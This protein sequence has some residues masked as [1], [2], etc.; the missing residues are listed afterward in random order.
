MTDVTLWLEN[1]Y[2]KDM[3]NRK[4]TMTDIRVII[5]EFVRGT[6]LREME[7]KLKISRTSLRA[8]RDR[9]EASGK[10]M[11][12]LLS[13]ED[14][15][16]NAILVKG[17]GHRSR[18]GDRYAFMMDNVEDYAHQMKRKYMT[19]EVLYEDYR[20]ATDNPYGYTQFKAIIQDYEKNHDYK[21]HNVYEP[22][23]EMQFDFAGDGLWIV[24]KSTGEAIQAIVLVCLLPYS[25][26]SYVTA[27]PSAKMEFLFQALSRAVEYFGGVAEISKTDN[28]RQ[29]I[30]KAHRYE[31]TLNEAASQWCLHYG[32]DLDECRSGKPRDK[33]PAESLVQQAYR[34]YYSRICRETFGSVDELNHRLDQLNDMFNNQERKNKTYTRREQYEKEELPFM[35]PLPPERFLFKYEKEI[36]INSTYH[37]QVDRN[38]FYSIPYQYIG[39]KAKVVYDAETVEVWVDFVRIAAHKRMYT[40]GYTTITEHMPP[41]H[42]AYQK[43]KEINA[44]Y[45]LSRAGLIGPQTRAS[46]E[47]ILN[48]AVFVQQ[49]YRSCQGVLRLATRYGADRLE[50]ACQR[51]EPKTAST[52]KRIEGI[53]KNNLDELPLFTSDTAPY[54]PENENVRG[55]A[56]YQ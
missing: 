35:L 3:A 39:K 43:S 36:T 9:A 4:A 10:S 55:A 37:F 21:Y 22:G 31:P 18:D 56:E 46:I 49:A 50:A 44:A 24:D 13:L 41:K 17:D 5:R 8:Y 54:I 7:R 23:R 28:M 11:V 51:I 40:D 1:K 6:S 30:K 25:M 45:L 34:C 14:A 38:H 29:W 16:L 47:S 2:H 12:E 15:E 52:Y 42:Q 19:Y 48:T 26:L 27:L 20:K 32:T 33:G 53:L